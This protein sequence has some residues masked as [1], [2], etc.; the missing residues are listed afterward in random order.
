VVRTGSI[1]GLRVRPTPWLEQTRQRWGERAIPGD[2]QKL[3]KDF[4]P[5]QKLVHLTGRRAAD[6]EAELG[7]RLFDEARATY[8]ETIQD[9]LGKLGCAGRTA[10][11]PAAGPE[12]SA[13]K[14]RSNWAAA[15]V[16]NT[17]NVELAKEIARIGEDTPT[18]N[19]NVYAYRLFHGTGWDEAYWRDKSTEVAQTESITMVNAAIADFYARNGDMLQ[20]TASVLPLAAVCSICQEMVAGNPWRSVDEVFRQFDIPP[21]PACPHYVY[22]ISGRISNEECMLLWAGE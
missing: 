13:I 18:A 10:V 16:A 11:A 21:H 22:A 6:Y 19:R 7:K 12:L 4:S 17:Y 15:S 3:L 2:W 14:D 8:R 5:V 20:P 9:E 1:F